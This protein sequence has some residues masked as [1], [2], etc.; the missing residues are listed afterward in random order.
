MKHFSIK[1]WGDYQHGSGKTREYPWL[2]LYGSLFRRHWF[3]EMQEDFRYWTICLLDYSR[4]NNNKN[5]ENLETFFRIYHLNFCTKKSKTWFNLLISNDFVASKKIAQC[6]QDA[7][8]I[9]EEERRI[10]EE[11]NKKHKYGE[12]KNVLL[13][14]EEHSKLCKKFGADGCHQQISNLDNGIALKGYKYKSH[15]LAILQWNRKKET[16]TSIPDFEENKELKEIK[17]IEHK[18]AR[19]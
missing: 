9:R 7:S 2:K 16:K 1:S 17:K 11:K 10:R 12:F 8:P 18:C 3:V 4:E 14:D 13:T 19:G 5:P 6:Y 15:Y